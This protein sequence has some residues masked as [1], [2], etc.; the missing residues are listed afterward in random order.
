MNSTQRINCNSSCKSLNLT[1]NHACNKCKPKM[2]RLSL[3][4]ETSAKFQNCVQIWHPRFSR[5]RETGILML[6]KKLCEHLGNFVFDGDKLIDEY[7]Y[8]A[9]SS[10]TQ[11][12]SPSESMKNH[13]AEKN[14]KTTPPINSSTPKSALTPDTTPDNIEEKIERLREI[15]AT[16]E[17]K[18]KEYVSL[19]KEIFGDRSAEFPVYDSNKN[20]NHLL[21]GT[22]S[23]K[24]KQKTRKTSLKHQQ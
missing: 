13:C 2:K 24:H 3:R 15:E 9:I 1:I 22:L 20:S 18:L 6:H 5:H 17:L 19:K 7:M 16:I 14:M 11:T 8:R 10:K 23:P 21:V 4:Q 12:V